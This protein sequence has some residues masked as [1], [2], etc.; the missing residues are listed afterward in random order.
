MDF[1]KSFENIA[2]DSAAKYPLYLDAIGLEIICS[3]LKDQRERLQDAGKWSTDYES[4]YCDGCVFLEDTLIKAEALRD[5][6]S[7]DDTINNLVHQYINLYRS[8]SDDTEPF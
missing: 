6:A 4:Q 2:K 7:A 8:V 3:S 1:Q 5:V